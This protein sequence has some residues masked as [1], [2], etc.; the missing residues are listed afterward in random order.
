MLFGR[1]K[2]RVILV[3]NLEEWDLE[4]LM[5]QL[6]DDRILDIE[7]EITKGNTSQIRDYYRDTVAYHTNDRKELHRR[8]MVIG[9]GTVETT[10]TFSLFALLSVLLDDRKGWEI[11]FDRLGAEFDPGFEFLAYLTRS[12]HF[13][14]PKLG[15]WVFLLENAK[16]KGHVPATMVYWRQRLGKNIW[17]RIFFWAP[18]KF[19]VCLKAALIALRYPDDRRLTSYFRKNEHIL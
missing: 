5:S 4:N 6:T 12:K 15:D 13:D 9:R 8:R 7:A 17:S 1:T 14:G 18:V 19:F 16:N 2:R 11:A 10:D 3:D